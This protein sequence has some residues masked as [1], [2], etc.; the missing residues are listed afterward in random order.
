[1]GWWRRRPSGPDPDGSPSRV[2][3]LDD[4]GRDLEPAPSP[5]PDRSRRVTTLA[6]ATAVVVIAVGVVLVTVPFGSGSR[7]G[8][9]VVT[10]ARFGDPFAL[11]WVSLEPVDGRSLP[12]SRPLPMASL[13]PPCVGFGRPDWPEADRHPTVAHCG[14]RS[15]LAGLDDDDLALVRTILA[16]ADTWYLFRFGAPPVAITAELSPNGEDAGGRPDGGAG[17]VGGDPVVHQNGPMGAVSVPTGSGPLRVEW[18]LAGGI[19]RHCLIGAVPETGP[20]P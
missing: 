3:L 5:A 4:G 8:R 13:D 1:M 15:D 18:E 20:C 19:R 6:A 7:P 16:G 9:L 12:A 14:D 2:E 11:D 17:P 10:S